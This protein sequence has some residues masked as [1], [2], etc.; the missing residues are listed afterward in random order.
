MDELKEGLSPEE[1]EQAVRLFNVQPDGNFLDEA[2]RQKTGAN[3]LHLTERK[4]V[5]EPLRKKLFEQRE[6]RSRPLKDTKVLT[7]W[8]GLMI[9]ALAKAARLFHRPEYQTAAEQAADFLLTEMQENG[10]L[11]HRWWEGHAAVPGQ[12]TDY[13]FLIRGL[14]ELYETTFDARWLEVASDLNRTVMNRFAD[15]ENG[16]F[17]Q[18]HCRDCFL[19]KALRWTL[20][21]KAI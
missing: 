5:P 10:R 19:P 8:N 3:I 4:T 7:D 17:Y 2:A 14:L 11:M 12:L 15:G 16:D 6:R 13:A 1:V 9:A 18:T 21:L 20:R